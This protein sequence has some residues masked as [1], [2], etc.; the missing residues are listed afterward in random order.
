[1]EHW[2]HFQIRHDHHQ[3]PNSGSESLTDF[4]LKTLSS[5]DGVEKSFQQYVEETPR[6]K[7]S[8]SCKIIHFNNLKLMQ[9]YSKQKS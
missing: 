7:G 3:Q 2:K 1:M 4:K 8:L 5:R 9:F 6:E